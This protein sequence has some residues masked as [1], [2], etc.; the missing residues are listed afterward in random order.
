MSSLFSLFLLSLTLSIAQAQVPG[1]ETFKFVNEGEFGPYVVEYG[2]NYRVLS[3][4]NGPFQL[5][6]Y[7]TTPNAFT[8]ALRMGRTRSESLLRWV[9]EANRGNP[10]GEKATLTFGTNGNLVLAHADGRVAWQTNTADKGVVGLKLLPNGNLVLHDCE[11]NFVWQSFDSPT[12]TLLVGQSLRVPRM[13]VSRFS[14]EENQKG[15]YL[16]VLE[17][18]GFS[19]YYRGLKK[20]LRYFSSAQRFG[21]DQGTLEYVTLEATPENESDD[22]SPYSVTLK[23][24]TGGSLSFARPKY[25]ATLSFMRLEI[26]GNVQVYT[27]DDRVDI[28]A[29]EVVFSLFDWQSVWES[30]C[31]QPSRCG[32][33][34]VCEDNQCVACPSERGLLGW[35]ATCAPPKVIICRR[36]G[37]RYFK[38][39]GVDHFVS[40]YTTGSAVAKSDCKKKCTSDCKCLGYFYHEDTSRCWVANELMTLTKVDNS[41]HVGYIKTP[42]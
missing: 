14:A 4:Y 16:F 31:Q 41:S 19:L 36:S 13:L 30:E 28:Q 3:I 40:K 39:E 21:S 25:N 35:D 29:W 22:C 38:V 17:T 37:Y 32:T 6:F 2:G 1:N 23:E 26:D 10:V 42:K 12:D 8:L 7:N 27:Y 15:R 20:P 18:K 33:F 11:G 5:C 34:G 24:S 9:W